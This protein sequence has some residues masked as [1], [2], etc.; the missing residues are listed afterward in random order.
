MP[1]YFTLTPIG[2]D[3]PASLSSIDEALAKHLNIPIHPEYYCTA[4][5]DIEGLGFALGFDW[6]T[7]RSINPTRQHIVDWFETNYSLS[8]WRQ[9]RQ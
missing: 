7:L 9:H 1:S 2:S 3:T 8:V 4:W 5:Y 6:N